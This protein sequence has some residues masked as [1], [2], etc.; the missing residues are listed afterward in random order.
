MSVACRIAGALVFILFCFCRTYS[1]QLQPAVE[2]APQNRDT[3]AAHLLRD[4]WTYREK[5]LYT[6][7]MKAGLDA[8]T[9]YQQEGNKAGMGSAYLEVA[10]VYQHIGEDKSNP[11]YIAQ[12]IEY[13]K[14]GYDLY[15][16][17]PDPAGEVSSRNIQGIL[18]RSLALLGKTAY[19][20][21]AL[22][23]YQAALQRMN[24][25]G[26]GREYAGTLYNNISQVYIEYKRDYPTALRYLQQAVHSNE[27]IH[28]IRKLSYNYGNIAHV[29]QLMGDKRRSLEY[30]SLTLALAEQLGTASRLL[31]AYQQLY[32][33]YR[34]FG[35]ADSALRYYVLYDQVRDSITNLGTTKQIAEMQTKYETEKSHSTIRELNER[36]RAQK[37]ELLLLTV[38]IVALALLVAVLILLFRRVMRQK[39]LIG[40]Q[41]GQ[42]EV[43]MKELHH[44][45]KNN[46]QIVSSLLSLQ[47][48]RLQDAEAQEAIR[49]SQQRVQAMSFIHQRLYAG[50]DTRMVN[51]EEYIGDLA[52]TL[53]MAYGY[54][55]ETM[56]L[57]IAVSKKWLDVD[58][59]LPL[60]L[61]AN[62][63]IT[64]ALKYA[65]QGVERPALRIELQENKEVI[66]LSIS[67]NGRQWDTSVW[68]EK[69]G[70]FGK[71][72]ITTLCRQLNA[73]QELV[74][75]DG[76]VFTFT[77]PRERAA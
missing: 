32:D 39:R 66:W 60:G 71:Q 29:Y 55:K 38:G 54:F 75:R 31:N 37:R 14:D 3:L 8:L 61:I 19:Y 25:S 1:Q 16:S 57:T 21:S 36:N 22:W 11:V 15:H 17:L 30:A 47:S 33:S 62:E 2:A 73:R 46:L 13:A 76:S 27:Q 49:L 43:M 51:M 9:I 65:Y 18:H 44:R 7:S 52:G 5:G 63:I 20:D 41:S 70:S 77:I 26:Q 50:S 28:S 58:K 53:M 34:T 59:A 69:G 48:Y 6:A 67:D 23:F 42:L 24:E 74:I 40:E 35:P 10:Q 4:C 72:L 56:E 64:N 45:V 12:G 68:T